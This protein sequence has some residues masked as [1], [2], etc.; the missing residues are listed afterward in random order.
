MTVMPRSRS[1]SACSACVLRARF[2]DCADAVG[3]VG[4]R[5]RRAAGDAERHEHPALAPGH[6]IAGYPSRFAVEHHAGVARLRLDHRAPFRAPNLLVAGEQSDERRRRPAELREGC[7]HEA[8]HHEARLHVGDAGTISGAVA[9]GERPTR[10]LAIGEHRVAMAH[11]HDVAA[12]VAGRAVPGNRGAQAVAVVLL[13]GDC[14]RYAVRLHEA[15]HHRAD[16]VDSRLVVAAAV[17]VH[18]F[19]EQ[20]D[21]RVVLLGEPGGDVGFGCHE[22]ISLGVTEHHSKSRLHVTTQGSRNSGAPRI[23]VTEPHRPPQASGA[24]RNR[25]AQPT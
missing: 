17:D 15:M 12:G 23:S 9:D 6:H 13:G 25:N 8:V 14:H 5:V 3:E 2:L 21:H 24:D 18:H 7:E 22:N 1:V 16:G 19:A 20:R 10:Y 11:Q 4:A